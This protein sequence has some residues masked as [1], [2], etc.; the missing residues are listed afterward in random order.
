MSL[1]YSGAVILVPGTLDVFYVAVNCE[2]AQVGPCVGVVELPAGLGP[3]TEKLFTLRLSIPELGS[4]RN[5]LIF[6]SHLP[7][8]TEGGGH[9]VGRRR[10]VSEPLEFMIMK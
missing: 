4:T 1:I 7:S 3:S 5:P 9:F 8:N 2:W 10:G 6:T